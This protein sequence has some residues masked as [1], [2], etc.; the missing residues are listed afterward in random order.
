V[1][2]VKGFTREAAQDLFGRQRITSIVFD[3]ELIYPA[4]RRGY[5]FAIVPIRWFDKRDRGCVPGP[6]G[7]ARRVGLFRIPLIHRG[8]PQRT[9]APDGSR[10]RCP[11]GTV[12]AADRGDP[13]A[14]LGIAA[15]GV[16]WRTLGFDFLAYYQAA[17]RPDGQALYDMSY[18]QTGGFGLFYYRR[19]SPRCCHWPPVIGVT[20]SWIALSMVVFLFVSRCCPR[21]ARSDGGR[22][23]G[24]VVIPVRVRGRRQVG[25]ILSG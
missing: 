22:F 12:G 25:P 23:A 6:P 21:P 9:E 8:P 7:A 24:R 14:R 19:P 16:R 11:A 3:V 2:E 4:R 18:T 10:G 1:R 20:W 17:V 15:T 13:L 5:R